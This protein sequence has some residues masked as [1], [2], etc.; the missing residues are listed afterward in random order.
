MVANA[1][2][3]RF[4]M[5]KSSAISGRWFRSLQHLDRIVRNLP[6]I[7]AWFSNT[8]V[9][10]DNAPAARRTLPAGSGLSPNGRAARRCHDGA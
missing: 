7:L 8:L 3:A 1:A 9:N 10:D 6:A 2:L 4:D 5:P